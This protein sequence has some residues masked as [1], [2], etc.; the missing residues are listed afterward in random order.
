MLQNAM[1]AALAIAESE[2]ILTLPRRAAMKIATLLPLRV[3]E[4]P[5]KIA[6]FEVML[7]WHERSHRN[8]QHEWVRSQIAA[9][10]HVQASTTIAP[11]SDILESVRF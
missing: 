8:T 9:F 10:A 6:P 3:M 5:I 2:M 1:G 11:V 4:A 7:L